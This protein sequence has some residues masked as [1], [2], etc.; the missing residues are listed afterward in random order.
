MTTKK[1]NVIDKIKNTSAF[2]WSV[3]LLVIALLSGG[4]GFLTYAKEVT[5]YLAKDTIMEIV[6]DSVKI[7]KKEMSK[8]FEKVQKQQDNM[9]VLMMEAFPQF[10]EAAEKKADKEKDNET[11]LNAIKG[12]NP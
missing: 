8:D 4:A 9:I 5:G 2:V 1:P 6:S 3:R 10:R 7:V 12:D 11:L